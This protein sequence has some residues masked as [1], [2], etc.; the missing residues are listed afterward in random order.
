MKTFMIMVLVFFARQSSKGLNLENV[1]ALKTYKGAAEEI[2]ITDFK[3]HG[4]FYRYAGA[5]AADG[6]VI[7]ADGLN[8]LWQRAYNVGLGV[9]VWWWGAKG[10]GLANDLP[11]FQAAFNYCSVPFTGEFKSIKELYWKPQIMVPDGLYR[12]TSA[13]KYGGQT[14]SAADAIKYE[15]YNKLAPSYSYNEHINKM[16]ATL[17]V[18]LSF[19]SR[20]YIWG[21]FKADSLT[22]IVSIGAVGYVYGGYDLQSTKISGLKIMG[23][24]KMDMK[25]NGKGTK[26]VGLLLTGN[27]IILENCGFYG[28]E[29]GMIHNTAYFNT[30]ISFQAR[31]CQRGYYSLGCHNT[32]GLGLRAD[33][34]EVGIEIRSGASHYTGISTEE[35]EKGLIIG[36]GFNSFSGVY[37]E[38]SD[39]RSDSSKYQLQIGYN[40]ASFRVMGTTIEGLTIAG[41]YGILM[42]KT[43]RGLRITGSNFVSS[44]VKTTH[45]ENSLEITNSFTD[46]HNYQVGRIVYPDRPNPK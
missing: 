7:V 8:R 14:L 31:N 42:N 13:F 41:A 22:A 27:D 6:G 40:D 44:A 5:D 2:V 18:S 46:I 30:V 21:D 36:D 15:W 28:L 43:A 26:Q 29:E 32:R 20:A 39:I 12:F 23:R 33:H 38:K 1:A 17:P 19:G 34:C 45:P 24:N 10:D 4:N 16:A 11:A 9:N 37:L 35:C 25:Q 3:E